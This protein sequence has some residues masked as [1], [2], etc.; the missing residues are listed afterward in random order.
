MAT[1]LR[2]FSGKSLPALAAAGF[3][4]AGI[5]LFVPQS[6]A[7][8]TY[9]QMITISPASAVSKTYP[10][11]PAHFQAVAFLLSYSHGH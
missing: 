5:G 7:A 3:I 4:P 8:F 11:L 6:H 9:H 1:A 10:S 2:K